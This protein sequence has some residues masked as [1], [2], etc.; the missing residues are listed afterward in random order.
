[1]KKKVRYII[2]GIVAAALAAGL[3]A[4][5][6]MDF[7][8]EETK[9]IGFSAYQAASVLEDGKIDKELKE[10]VTSN[11]IT[12]NG[13]KITVAED[14]AVSYRV[15]WY[16]EMKGYLSAS[17]PFTGDFTG[18]IPDGAK[19]CRIEITP[20]SDEDGVVSTFEIPGYVALLEVTVNK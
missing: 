3:I 9:T 4:N 19:Y 6:A 18:T 7:D 11:L 17:G 1:M 8:R 10:N 20:T 15:H 5:F 16:D 14:A 12:T 2:A 13:L